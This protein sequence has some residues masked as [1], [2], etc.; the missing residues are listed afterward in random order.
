MY[1]A[2]ARGS[3]ANA[4]LASAALFLARCNDLLVAWSI[5]VLPSVCGTNEQLH[6]AASASCEAVGK[7]QASLP[8][9]RRDR[10][11]F[12]LRL[13]GLADRR[14]FSRGGS[15]RGGGDGGCIVSLLWL[16]L[17]AVASCV[18]APFF[19]IPFW[20][21]AEVKQVRVRKPRGGF[22]PC[23][24]ETSRLGDA[25]AA[26]ARAEI[27]IAAIERDG[28]AL[29]LRHKHDGTFDLRNPQAARLEEA[30]ALALP[31][32]GAVQRER[33]AV[34]MAVLSRYF[35]WSEPQARLWS[36]R[37]ALGALTIL[38]IIS[39]SG[40][41]SW[42]LEVSRVGT[43]EFVGAAL[44]ATSFWLGFVAV[45][46]GLIGW[47]ISRVVAR[48]GL[49]RFLEPGDV[50][51]T[52]WAGTIVVATAVAAIGGG[53]LLLVARPAIEGRFLRSAGTFSAPPVP[54]VRPLDVR[55][56]SRTPLAPR[57]PKGVNRPVPSPSN[58]TPPATSPS[59]GQTEEA[60]G[61]LN[62]NSIPASECSL[63]GLVLGDTPRVG[64]T[65]M[66]GVHSVHFLNAEQGVDETIS[67][68]VGAGETRAATFRKPTGSD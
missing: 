30:R 32:R 56:A 9:A 33:Q 37:L 41:T 67:V 7:R 13:D 66:P 60:D 62:I 36:L 27:V 10:M 45:G 54:T 47:G 5:D 20:I 39:P 2:T 57:Q 44:F 35:A 64:V 26:E 51:R 55:S 38:V 52:P 46:G 12:R 1:E 34:R 58:R 29:G 49:P 6:S 16:L 61:H 19:L 43:P 50:E 15:R 31:A 63:D 65:V 48:A 4:C 23:A 8:Q 21:A 42:T 11:G 22:E 24:D 17:V 59:S 3:V 53:M 40:L 68:T 18:L 28:E 25:A 14:F